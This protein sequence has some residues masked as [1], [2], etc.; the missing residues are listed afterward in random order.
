MKVLQNFESHLDAV[1]DN[2]KVQIHVSIT[3]QFLYLSIYLYFLLSFQLKF[4]V[5]DDNR[6]QIYVR[7]MSQ[8]FYLYLFFMFFIEFSV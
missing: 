2:N 8:F 1:D 6:V 3:S 7:V 4:D 5:T